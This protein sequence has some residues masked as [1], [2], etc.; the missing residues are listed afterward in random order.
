[1]KKRNTG[2]V[3]VKLD[4]ARPPRMDAR[5]KSGLLRTKPGEI[6][7]S[8]IPRAGPAAKW[9]RPGALVRVE[10]KKQITLRLDLEVIDFFKAT[11]RKYQ[12]RINEV[13]REYARAH[14]P[15]S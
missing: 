1:M 2:L 11:G 8:D 15:S 13:L 14:N 9:T 10:N 5:T 3:E 6:D 4:P 12:S 7:Y